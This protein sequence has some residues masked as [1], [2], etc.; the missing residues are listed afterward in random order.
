MEQSQ[1]AYPRKVVKLGN[2]LFV[3]IPSAIINRLEI[4][5]GHYVLVGL[6][7]GIILVKA[8]EAKLAKKDLKISYDTTSPEKETPRKS[9]TVHGMVLTIIHWKD[10]VSNDKHLD[11]F[12]ILV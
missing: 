6:S 10:S 5:S 2:S 7:D 4:T 1:K 12:F 9:T 8:M 3:N 11:S